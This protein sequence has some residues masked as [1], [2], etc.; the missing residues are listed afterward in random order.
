MMGLIDISNRPGGFAK[1]AATAKQFI[2]SESPAAKELS[3][4]RGG[5]FLAGP[6]ASGA[7]AIVRCVQSITRVPHPMGRL[8]QLFYPPVVGAAAV[9]CIHAE[10]QLRMCL[11]KPGAIRV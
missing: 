4:I 11:Q 1:L 9:T 7:L 5:F 8:V 10:R 6:C 3:C 2:G